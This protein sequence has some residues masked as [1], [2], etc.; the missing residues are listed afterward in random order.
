MVGVGIPPPIRVFAVDDLRDQREQAHRPD[1][2]GAEAGEE[3]P[4]AGEVPARAL[5]I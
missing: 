2:A 1:K 3:T 5:G 4:Q